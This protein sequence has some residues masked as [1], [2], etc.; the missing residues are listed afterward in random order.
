MLKRKFRIALALAGMTQVEWAKKHQISESSLSLL[1]I[2]KMKSRR[3]S[4]SIKHFIDSEYKKRNLTD[5][6][7]DNAAA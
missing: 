7:M 5:G 4:I 2:G 3:L 6:S 1:L